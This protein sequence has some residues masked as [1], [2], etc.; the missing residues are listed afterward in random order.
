MSAPVFTEADFNEYYIT[1]N[2]HNIEE[3]DRKCMDTTYTGVITTPDGRH[4]K[5]MYVENRYTYDTTCYEDYT[6][7][8]FAAP[9]VTVTTTY[10]EDGAAILN[11]PT[12]Y[13]PEQRKQ[14][15]HLLQDAL[16][17]LN[18]STSN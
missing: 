1:E 14:Y 18:T 6:R 4:Y 9:T 10:T 17:S 16:E 7:E 13:S 15:K 11:T 2:I 3:I 5:V 8:V 12:H